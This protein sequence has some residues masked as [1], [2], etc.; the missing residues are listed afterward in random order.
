MKN[1]LI[2]TDFSPGSLDMIAA[3]AAGAD[4]KVNI[5]LFHAFDMP[6][7][8]VD[9]MMRTGANGHY[10]MVTE[11]LRVKC[12]KIKT[13]NQMVGNISFKFMYGT[14][15][16]LFR[17]FAAAYRLDMIA[18]PENYF[19]VQ[20]VRESVN[21]LHMFKKSGIPVQVFSSVVASVPIRYASTNEAHD[22]RVSM[23][24]E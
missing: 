8:L 14:S 3:V 9:A 1:V 15:V 20:V 18:L 5:I 6:V 7:S 12:R 23:A 2:P 24:G 11:N 22:R 10:S 16:A 4:E 17:N 19:F 21:P 13:S